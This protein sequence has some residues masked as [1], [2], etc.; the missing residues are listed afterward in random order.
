MATTE[1][2]ETGTGLRRDAI[3]LREVLFQSITDGDRVRLAADVAADVSLPRQGFSSNGH[4]S[5]G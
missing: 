3:G 1:R 5:A 2:T 4:A